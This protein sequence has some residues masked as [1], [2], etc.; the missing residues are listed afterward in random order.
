MYNYNIEEVETE[1]VFAWVEIWVRFLQGSAQ[2]S[3]FPH[4]PKWTNPS[5][6]NVLYVLDMNAMMTATLISLPLTTLVYVPR[7]NK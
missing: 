6:L 4:L 5:V 3:G 2:E 7:G 1:K